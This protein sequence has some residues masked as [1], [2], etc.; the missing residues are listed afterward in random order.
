MCTAPH[1]VTPLQ[2]MRVGCFY[3]FHAPTKEVC[4]SV[5]DDAKEVDLVHVIDESVVEDAVDLMD[6]QADKFV[7]VLRLKQCVNTYRRHAGV[8][9]IMMVIISMWWSVLPACVCL[10]PAERR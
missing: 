10:E 1:H 9:I 6:P 4:Q 3:R 7:P 5:F 2:D 8:I